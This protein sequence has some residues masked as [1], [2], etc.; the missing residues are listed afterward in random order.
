MS[1]LYLAPFEKNATVIIQPVSNGGFVVSARSSGYH[2]GEAVPIVG[3]FSNRDDL[4]V[5]LGSA[6]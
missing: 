1:D 5:A 4:L 3:A 2:P 6:F